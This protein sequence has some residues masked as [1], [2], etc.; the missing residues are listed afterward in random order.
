MDQEHSQ[1]SGINSSVETLKP[2]SRRRL[3]KGLAAGAAGLGVLSLSATAMAQTSSPDTAIESQGGSTGYGVDAS[4]GKAAIRLRPVSGGST[5][6]PS[7]TGHEVGELYVDGNGS[8]YYSVKADNAGAVKFR[9]LASANLAAT[10]S[11]HISPGTPFFFTAPDRLFDSRANQVNANTGGGAFKNL[12]DSNGN[13]VVGTALAPYAAP[14]T[15][16]YTLYV[17][18]NI[19]S[20]SQA[21]VCSKNG[22]VVPVGATAI[23]GLLCIVGSSGS[24]VVKL[25][26]DSITEDAKAASTGFVAGV[27]NGSASAFTVPLSSNG[28]LKLTTTAGFTGNNGIFIDVAGYYL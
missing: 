26:P 18:G 11:S 20:T 24:T 22:N 15:N 2:N 23:I 19:G 6:P 9:K 10:S 25:Y 3:L 12:L 17:T 7:A 14:S 16:V 4:G 21:V 28:T 27:G 13:A 1:L 8:L 5:T